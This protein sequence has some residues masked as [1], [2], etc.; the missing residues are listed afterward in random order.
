MR[1]VIMSALAAAIAL[2]ALVVMTWR[3]MPVSRA[4]AAQ[5]LEEAQPQ[6]ADRTIA[7]APIGPVSA[8]EEPDP[9][10]RE[11][12]PLLRIPADESARF[13]QWRVAEVRRVLSVYRTFA[14]EAHLSAEQ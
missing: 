12:S 3:M 2:S 6:P 13:E 8:A 5:R 9:T 11:G 14:T 7:P 4:H 10:R 1:I